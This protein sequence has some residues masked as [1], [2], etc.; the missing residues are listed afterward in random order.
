MEQKEILIKVKIMDDGSVF[1]I[2]IDEELQEI[3]KPKKSADD[4]LLSPE[5]AANFLKLPDK[6]RLN[7]LRCQGKI[8]VNC[9]KKIPGIGYRYFKKQ[10]YKFVGLNYEN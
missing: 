4:E 2:V 6:K 3:L 9:Y 7:D 8:P 5:E 1:P 10:L